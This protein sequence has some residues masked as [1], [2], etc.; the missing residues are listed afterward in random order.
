MLTDVAL[1]QRV[2][3][4]PAYPVCLDYSMVLNRCAAPPSTSHPDW[5]QVRLL[6]PAFSHHIHTSVLTNNYIIPGF[7]PWNSR[8]QVVSLVSLPDLN[9]CMCA[10]VCV[11][12][13]VCLCACV[14][15]WIEWKPKVMVLGLREVGGAPALW[16]LRR[17]RTQTPDRSVVPSN[18]RPWFYWQT[19]SFSDI[20]CRLCRQQLVVTPSV[21]LLTKTCLLKIQASE[22]THIQ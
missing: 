7:W 18:C 22:Y 11:C 9:V 20:L 6:K 8:E 4:S 15:V 10:C 16:N 1:P 2:G 14:R 3:W 17:A 13:C 5:A 21:C 12:V 19:S